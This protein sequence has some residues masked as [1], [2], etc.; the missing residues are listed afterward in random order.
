MILN[1]KLLASLRGMQLCIKIPN[2]QL[3]EP[4]SINVWI[5]F[6]R[7]ALDHLTN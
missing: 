2:Y 7:R 5:D 1:Y 4:N 6:L 3:D